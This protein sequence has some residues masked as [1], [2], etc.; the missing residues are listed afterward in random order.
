MFSVISELIFYFVHP[1]DAFFSLCVISI[2]IIRGRR[3]IYFNLC[4]NQLEIS[5]RNFAAK[6]K[7][8]IIHKPKSLQIICCEFF[9]DLWK[10]NVIGLRI[11]NKRQTPA[12]TKCYKNKVRKNICCSIRFE[13]DL[14]YFYILHSIYVLARLNQIGLSLVTYDRLYAIFIN[15]IWSCNIV[16]FQS[17][18]LM[19]KF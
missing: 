15:W 10:F 9:F 14:K 1:L 19:L 18:L 16:D 11:K 4:K 3:F 17:M 5:N 2:W 12:L 6:A 8:K 13:P 7:K